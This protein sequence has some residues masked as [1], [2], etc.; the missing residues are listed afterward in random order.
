MSLLSALPLPTRQHQQA[1]QVVQVPAKAASSALVPTSREA[2]PYPRRAGFVPRRADDYNDG[3]AYPEIH[4]A[5]FPL[6]MGR[7][8][9]TDGMGQAKGSKTLAVTV[10]A[11]GQVNYDAIVKQGANRDKLVYSDHKALVPKVDLLSKE[12]L[13]KPDQEEVD[14]TAQETMAALQKVVTGKVSI[15]NPSTLPS[16]S[17]ASTLIKYTPTQQG[18]QVDHSNWKIPPAISNWKNPKGYTIP[19]DKRLAAD[20]RGLQSTT[21]NDK[22]AAL[23]E[24]LFTAESKAREAISMRA[25]IQKQLLIKEKAKKETELRDLALRARTERAAGGGM[26]GGGM[27]G[28]MPEESRP[29]GACGG[30]GGMM[31]GGMMGSMPEAPMA[32]MDAAS[33]SDEDDD[34]QGGARSRGGAIGI[35]RPS[36]GGRDG[37]RDGGGGRHQAVPEENETREE[38]EERKRRDEIREE[39]RRERERERRLESKDAHGGKKSKLTRDRDR[40][41]SEKVALGMA[42]VPGGGEVMYDQ[43]LFNQEQGMASGFGA[44][45]SYNTYDKPLFAERASANLFR[46]TKADGEQYGGGLEAEEGGV[47]SDKFKAD[48][49]FK[50]A[51]VSAGPRSRPVEFER[52]VEEADPFGLDQFLSEVKGKGRGKPNALDGIGKGGGMRAAG[53]GAN[54]DNLS[55]EGSGRKMQFTSGS[56]R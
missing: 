35:S 13:A 2:P 31:G 27:M 11:E 36:D 8:S 9:S 51:D 56:G 46:P 33:D 39:R 43:R 28:S 29:G 49:G 1:P 48:K 19:L 34:R 18:S 41:V 21:I 32:Q 15:A 12:A 37:E 20:G 26:M 38:R 14:K 22:F 10:N 30:G 17:G 16:Q 5:Q 42:K 4:V 54:L 55:A 6:D 24:G 53:G 7:S 40:D 45:D 23:S 44:E 3:G 47:R 50:G 52:N 25:E